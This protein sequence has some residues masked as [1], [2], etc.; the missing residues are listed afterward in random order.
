MTSGAPLL[1][2]VDPYTSLGHIYGFSILIG[3]G[4][5][6]TFQLGYIVGGVK[7]L[8]QTGS[9]KSVQHVISVL[10]LAQL[11]FQLLTLLKGGQIFQSVAMENLSQALSDLRYSQEELR[12]L[13]TGTQSRVY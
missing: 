10:N 1:S 2:T 5:G 12:A 8:L 7:T 11:G 6:L 13:I 4:A 3:A 9:G